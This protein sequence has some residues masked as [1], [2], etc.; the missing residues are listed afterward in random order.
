MVEKKFSFFFLNNKNTHVSHFSRFIVIFINEYIFV[1][2][3]NLFLMFED[4]ICADVI[5]CDR[6]YEIT[7][8]I[9]VH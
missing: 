5:G 8:K 2:R 1:V 7:L 6:T 9:T 4:R 3:I